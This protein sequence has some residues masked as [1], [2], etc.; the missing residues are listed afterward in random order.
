MEVEVEVEVV[1]KVVVGV[2]PPVTCI[3]AFQKVVSTHSSIAY[4][5]IMKK[6]SCHVYIA[7]Y[8]EPCVGRAVAP[9][10][11][12][13]SKASTSTSR[14]ANVCGRNGLTTVRISAS[15]DDE[16]DDPATA[17]AANPLPMI[18]AGSIASERERP[19]H[20]SVNVWTIVDARSWRWPPPSA[21]EPDESDESDGSGRSMPNMP[22]CTSSSIMYSKISAPERERFTCAIAKK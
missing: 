3:T 8:I 16:F 11:F 2:A 19:S 14:I 13:S 18:A 1:G 15:Y 20:A 7:E 6:P 5:S 4:G 17:A 21:E 9:V 12:T 10:P 22:R